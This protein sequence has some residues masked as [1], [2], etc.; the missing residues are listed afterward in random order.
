MGQ[1][2]SREPSSRGESRPQ[3]S[4]VNSSIIEQFATTP[5]SKRSHDSVSSSDSSCTNPLL[6]EETRFLVK[7][8]NETTTGGTFAFKVNPGETVGNFKS[9]I[10]SK[11]DIPCAEQHLYFAVNE[12]ED[13]RTLADYISSESTVRIFL[14]GKHERMMFVKFLTGKTTTLCAEPSDTIENVKSKIQDIEGIPFDQQR[15]IF[16]GKQL[17]D[18]RTVSEY[19]IQKES[20][21]HCILRLR[22]GMQIFAKTLSGKTITLE[23]EPSDTIENVRSKIQDKEGISSDQYHII[24]AGKKLKDRKTLSDYNVQKESTLRMVLARWAVKVLKST[25]GEIITLHIKRRGATVE[26]IKDEIQETVNNAPKERQRLFY[27]GEELEDERSCS[28]YNISADC[29]LILNMRHQNGMQIKAKMPNTPV[30]RPL[31]LEVLGDD[32][33]RNIKSKIT[34]LYSFPAE[35]INCCVR[36]KGTSR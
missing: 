13:S 16:D 17:E 34:L 28:F 24:F 25:T 21:I 20:T 5:Y 19:N 27:K 6:V 29:Q 9:K 30:D 12:L 31:S 33:I 14:H 15:L 2:Y 32:T 26:D 4:P 36:R 1:L 7:N 35:N 11:L 22:G 23:V 8:T 18:D 10:Q 3:S